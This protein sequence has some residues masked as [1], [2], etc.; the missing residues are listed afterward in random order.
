MNYYKK[1]QKYLT[2]VMNDAQKTYEWY[3]AELKKGEEVTYA[4]AL[5]SIDSYKENM[6]GAISFAF[7][8]DLIDVEQHDEAWKLASAMGS[9]YSEKLFDLFFPDI[10][11][12]TR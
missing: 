4:A 11:K 9:G 10:R 7:L 12:E 2:H 5:T 8:E 1:L 3:A 6:F